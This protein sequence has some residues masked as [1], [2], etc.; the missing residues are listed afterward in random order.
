MPGRH[1]VA[2]THRVTSTDGV[3]GADGPAVRRNFLRA[4]RLI[5]LRRNGIAHAH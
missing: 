2:G 3:T 4:F 5:A 1:R